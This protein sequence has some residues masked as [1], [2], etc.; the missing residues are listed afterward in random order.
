MTNR[1]TE[2]RKFCRA[3]WQL[4]TWQQLEC[5]P[6][7]NGQGGAGKGIESSERGQDKDEHVAV[8]KIPIRMAGIRWG[9]EEAGEYSERRHKSRSSGTGEMA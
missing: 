8:S 3:G 5:L 2:A 9:D 1:K 7:E 6:P 4:L